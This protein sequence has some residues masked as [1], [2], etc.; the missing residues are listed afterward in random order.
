MVAVRVMEVVAHEVVDVVAMGHRLVPAALAVGVIGV[1]VV[2][3]MLGG[4]AF[5]MLGIDLEHVLVDV[6]LVRVMQLAVVQ[7]VHVITVLDSG[8]TAAGTVP[9]GVL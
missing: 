7:V 4:A 3:G 9:V 8:V 1:V 6:I 2:T 5:G